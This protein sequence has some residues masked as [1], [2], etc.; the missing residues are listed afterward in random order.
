M[1]WVTTFLKSLWSGG[2]ALVSLFSLIVVTPVVA[3]YL[4]YDWHHM[5][6]SVDGWIPVHHR[7]TVHDAGARD[8]RHHLRLRARADH[9][10]L[11][12]SA[13]SMRLR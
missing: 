13:R 2:Q 7:D 5:V 6:D 9:G 12:C 1:G 10:L 3:F 11:W 8:R 4:I